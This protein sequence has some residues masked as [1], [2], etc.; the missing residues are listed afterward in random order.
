M[1]DN[2]KSVP[3]ISVSYSRNGTSTKSNALGMRPMQER[4]Y[5]RRGEQYLLIKSPPASGKSRA[6]MFIDPLTALLLVPALHLWL[7]LASPELRPRPLG[8]LALVLLALAP[9]ALLVAFFAHQLGLGGAE[10]AWAAALLLAGGHVGVL[11]AVLW[12]IALGCVGAVSIL[13]LAAPHEP[14]GTRWLTSDR[15]RVSERHV[16]WFARPIY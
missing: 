5:E 8:A 14:R 9:L 10:I 4:A 2:K 3:S 6:L 7:L 16:G 15:C 13:A 11:G 1:T 12:S